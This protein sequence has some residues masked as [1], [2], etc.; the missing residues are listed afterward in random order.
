MPRGY[1]LWCALEQ[2]PL[3]LNR[4]AALLPKQ[5]FC[6]LTSR[7]I[8]KALEDLNVNVVKSNLQRIPT[9]PVEFTDEQFNI[10]KNEGEKFYKSIGEVYCPYFKEKISPEALASIKKKINLA[11]LNSYLKKYPEKIRKKAF[12]LLGKK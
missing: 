1:E 2:L 9:S 11:K 5:G 6:L 3:V 4:A 10:I 8:A 7:K 12:S